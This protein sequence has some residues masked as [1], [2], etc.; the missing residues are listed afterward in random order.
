MS[1]QS[2]QSLVSRSSTNSDR[3]CTLPSELKLEI[4]TN[5]TD[6]SSLVSLL[7]AAKTYR[8][9]FRRYPEE[10][11]L[12][13]GRNEWAAG[14]IS[15]IPLNLLLLLSD[16]FEGEVVCSREEY[17]A[18]ENVPSVEGR[19]KRALRNLTT[20]PNL[21]RIIREKV[22]LTKRACYEF[23]KQHRTICH[24]SDR[25]A[26][27][28]IEENGSGR[29]P[30]LAEMT[31]IQSSFYR[32]WIA[33]EFL[34]HRPE[35]LPGEPQYK[36]FIFGLPSCWHIEGMAAVY[37][38]IARKI[39]G[40]LQELAQSDYYRLVGDVLLW[41][42]DTGKRMVETYGEDVHRDS[43]EYQHFNNRINPDCKFPIGHFSYAY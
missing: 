8:N 16:R 5:V 28:I 11:L 4:L 38:Y 25:Y 41:Q 21:G 10:V 24:Y 42:E 31:R 20:F 26:A 22:V 39:H 34:P 6:L 13:V 18:V 14:A 43:D 7:L 9:L 36:D 33:A 2:L 15:A 37:K 30:T 35:C 3:L 40:N 27:D 19:I 29:D 23:L 1:L 12:S 32:L 17:W